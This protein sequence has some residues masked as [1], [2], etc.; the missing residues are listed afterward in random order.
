MENKINYGKLIL[1][2]ILAAV[3]LMVVGMI[4]HGMI[5]ESHYEFFQKQGA[6]LAEPREMGWLVHVAGT[7]LSGMAISGLYVMGRKFSG[8]GPKT[9]IRVG[10]AVGLFTIGGAAAEYTFYNLGGMIPLLTWVG[11]VAG[12]ILAALVAGWVYKDPKV[13]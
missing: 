2:G 8:P 3:V 13:Q 1:G 7:L 10:W 9:A 12:A 11:N 4:V 5:L 6:V